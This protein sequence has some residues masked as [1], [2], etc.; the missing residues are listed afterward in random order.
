MRYFLD[1]NGLDKSIGDVLNLFYDLRN[2]VAFPIVF[3]A[4]FGLDVARFEDEYYE[5]MRTY[6]AGGE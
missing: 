4:N 3:Q 2:D 5:R 1:P 6:L